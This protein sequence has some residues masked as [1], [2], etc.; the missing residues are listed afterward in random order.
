MGVRALPFPQVILNQ[1][2]KGLTSLKGTNASA[3]G[4]E[5]ATFTELSEIANNAGQPE[6]VYKLMELSTASAAW[7][8]RKGMAFA[9]GEVALAQTAR[10][11][12]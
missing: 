2:V 4:G 9:L 3:S 1:L 11:W 10:P 5:M 12:T 6:L 7:N 8:T